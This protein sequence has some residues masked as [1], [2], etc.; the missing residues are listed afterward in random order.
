MFYNDLGFEVVADSAVDE[1]YARKL[2]KT[3][4]V[5]SEIEGTTEDKLVVEINGMNIIVTEMDCDGPC[6]TIYSKTKKLN[7]KLPDI[8]LYKEGNKYSPV[9]EVSGTEIKE[10]NGIF[11]SQQP[12]I[13]KLFKE[14]K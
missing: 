5:G 10:E 11:D 2:A 13:I 8:I 12:F 3:L 14:A 1:K 4:V 7:K 6:V 9:Y